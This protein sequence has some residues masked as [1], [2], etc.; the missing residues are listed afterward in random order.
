MM[1]SE[2]LVK[3]DDNAI[4]KSVLRIAVLCIV[5]NYFLGGVPTL[6]FVTGWWWGTRSSPVE[7][8]EVY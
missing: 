5:M 6:L 4:A 3:Q 1:A 2:R 7:D 8:E